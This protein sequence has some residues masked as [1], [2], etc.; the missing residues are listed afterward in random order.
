MKLRLTLLPILLAFFV[1]SGTCQT[2]AHGANL[3]WDDVALAGRTF[4]ILRSPTATGTKTVIQSG[5]TGT[6][7][8]DSLP[9]NTAACYFV[10]I[11]APGF[12]DG[13]PSDPA[14]GTSGKDS[15]PKATGLAVQFF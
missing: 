4:T 12:S 9:A 13:P 7:L 2:P 10:V 1:S 11:S 6:S 15:A 3:K 14:C 8:T 5:I